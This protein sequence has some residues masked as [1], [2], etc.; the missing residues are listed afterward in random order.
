MGALRLTYSESKQ[1]LRDRRQ[2]YLGTYRRF[3]KRGPDAFGGAL[4]IGNGYHDSLAAH[5]DGGNA[6]S[7]L[8][9]IQLQ[10]AADW[11]EFEEDLTKETSLLTAMVTGYL[12][13]LEQS[14]ADADLT[15]TGSERTLDVQLVPESELGGEI[16]LL[17]KLDVPCERAQDGFVGALEH[18][19]VSTL[20]VLMPLA[21]V[22]RQFLTEHLI[23]F[24]EL[25]HQGASGDEAMQACH[26]VM[27]NMARKVKR[28]AAAKPPF[29]G[30]ETV[31]HNIHELRNHWKHM[32]A[33]G[34]EIQRTRAR[35][36]AGESHHS[37]CPP[38]P[39][40]D[41]SWD[42]PF[43]KVSAMLDDGSDWEGALSELYEERDP[44]ER[45]QGAMPL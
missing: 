8:D 6:L 33:V 35:L 7:A 26:G 16:R 19:T 25:Q 24:L 34:R 29:Y 31:P 32:V 15:I 44:L 13:W 41:S 45:Y 23:R 38:N 10:K 37:V 42:D 36:D 18:K 3:H 12:E 21:K 28:T 30:R 17:S 5:Y 20:E 1:F 43:F 39:T 14:G 2:W 40:R 22:D 9:E 11:P 27:L 4:S